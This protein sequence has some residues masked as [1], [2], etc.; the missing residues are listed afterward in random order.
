VLVLYVV[1]VL[2]LKAV[3][4]IVFVALKIVDLYIADVDK[5]F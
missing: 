2:V 4:V 1:T 5:V 3:I